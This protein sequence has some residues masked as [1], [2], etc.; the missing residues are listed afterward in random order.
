MPWGMAR[1]HLCIFA[2]AKPACKALCEGN[3]GIPLLQ[4]WKE[5]SGMICCQNHTWML[6][7]SELNRV[8][9]NRTME[10]GNHELWQRSRDPILKTLSLSLSY[11]I[12]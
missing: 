7:W 8:V 3:Q 9:Q 12:I 10:Q 4:P 2:E 6:P 11:L 1:R 5:I